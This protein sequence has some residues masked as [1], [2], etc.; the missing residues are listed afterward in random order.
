MLGTQLQRIGEEPHA[1]REP[2]KGPDLV[3]TDAATSHDSASQ[4]EAKPASKDTAGKPSGSPSRHRRRGESRHMSPL[5]TKSFDI[6]LAT[7]EREFGRRSMAAVGPVLTEDIPAKPRDLSVTFRVLEMPLKGLGTLEDRVLDIEKRV[8][9]LEARADL[10]AR[11]EKVEQ[12]LATRA[13]D[14]EALDRLAAPF[15]KFENRIAE[16]MRRLAEIEMIAAPGGGGD[17]EP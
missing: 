5:L 1:T 13:S 15:T 9:A 7:P 8:R 16:L 12:Q 11:V 4:R 3:P 14:S 10:T 17:A 6:T 2:T